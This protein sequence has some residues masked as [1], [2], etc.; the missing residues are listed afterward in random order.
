MGRGIRSLLFSYAEIN[1]R[2]PIYVPVKQPG[3]F[4]WVSAALFL[5]SA[6]LGASLVCLEVE[7][8]GCSDMFAWFE[9]QKLE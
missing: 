1:I 7:G 8:F 4:E 6:L 5:V 9:D 2:S 3:F